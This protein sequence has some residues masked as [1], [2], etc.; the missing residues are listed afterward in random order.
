MS[1]SALARDSC[2][3]RVVV[4]R[5]RRGSSLAIPFGHARDVP[6]ARNGGGRG[7][8]ET[9][10]YNVGVKER[11]LDA[12]EGAALGGPAGV[13]F[14]RLALE[15]KELV[16]PE[17]VGEMTRLEKRRVSA[18]FLFFLFNLQSCYLSL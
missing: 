5:W 6:R 17:P 9:G 14:C 18:I 10:A 3:P 11:A 16:A 15:G 4:G 13:G 12:E 8:Q 1:G 2:D 7:I